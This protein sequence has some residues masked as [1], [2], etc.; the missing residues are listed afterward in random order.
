[1]NSK[2]LGMLA[3]GLLAG[4]VT[5]QAAVIIDVSEVSGDVVFAS[6]GTLNLT[7][8]VLDGTGPYADINEGIISGS[9]NW[10]YG[11]GSG[12]PVSVYRLASWAGPFGTNGSL[13]YLYNVGTSSGTPFAIWGSSYNQIPVLMISSSFIS[14]SAVTGSLVFAGKNFSSLGLTPGNYLYSLPNDTVT[15]RIGSRSV[16]PEPGTLALLGLGLAGLG[17]S[18]RRKAA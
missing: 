15:L 10:Y 18:R 3:V 13:D 5:A 14:G 1:M 11:Q 16:V 8:A 9:I 7:G 4:P 12:G 6:S 17:L 2:I